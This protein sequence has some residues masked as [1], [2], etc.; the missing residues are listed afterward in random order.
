MIDPQ[1]TPAI[2]AVFTGLSKAYL[3]P[4]Y[5]EYKACGI[6]GIKLVTILIFLS[7]NVLFSGKSQDIDTA[8]SGHKNLFL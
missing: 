8:E 3:P 7:F 6:H 2:C 1:H 4:K 5:W